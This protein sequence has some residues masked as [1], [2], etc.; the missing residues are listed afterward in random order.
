MA[1][2]IAGQLTDAQIALIVDEAVKRVVEQLGGA[3]GAAPFVTTVQ[4]GPVDL[5]D[6]ASMSQVIT[7]VHNLG[8]TTPNVSVQNS[9]GDYVLVPWNSKGTP[10][11]VRLTFGP[12]FTDVDMESGPIIAPPDT[13]TVRIAK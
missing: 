10:N 9:R 5:D 7:V 3:G 1:I 6:M 11:A 12:R 2:P 8:T 13:Y 4:P